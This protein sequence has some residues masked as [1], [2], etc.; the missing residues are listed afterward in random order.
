MGSGFIAA[1]AALLALAFV[2]GFGVQYPSKRTWM[3][4]RSQ[5]GRKAVRKMRERLEQTSHNRAPLILALVLLVG[6]VAWAVVATKVFDEDWQQIVFDSLSSFFVAIAMLRM[7]HAL[8]AA[9][10][11]MKEYERSLGEDPD[12]D[13]DA[14]EGDGGST[15][16]AL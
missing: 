3:K 15:A 12:A 10:E 2:E 9:A 7:P 14:D 16:I 5:N 1:V 11:R 6:I 4:L 13:L 8:R